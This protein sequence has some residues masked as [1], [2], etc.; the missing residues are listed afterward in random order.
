[1]M[2]EMTKKEIETFEL[3]ILE[4]FADFISWYNLEVESHSNEWGLGMKLIGSKCELFFS[5]D[6]GDL[7][8]SFINPETKRQYLSNLVY[9][10]FYPKDDTYTFSINDSIEDQLSTYSRMIKDRFPKILEGDF[11]W[12]NDFDKRH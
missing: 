8:C 12:A 4:K 2:I 7:R 1:M 11:S 10:K 3:I 6:R 9:H 5:H